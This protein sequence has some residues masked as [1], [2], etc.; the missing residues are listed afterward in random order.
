MQLSHVFNGH[1]FNA[2]AHNMFFV[3]WVTFFTAGIGVYVLNIFLR[4]RPAS[5]LALVNYCFPF[6]EWKT[7]SVRIDVFLY[8]L[9]IFTNGA[10]ALATDVARV[11]MAACVAFVLNAVVPIHTPWKADFPVVIML[12]VVL[13]VMTDFAGYVS[14]YLL[15]FVPCL[16][17]LHKVHHSATFLTPFT[18]RR[19]HPLENMF[20]GAFVAIFGAIPMGLAMHMYKLDLVSVAF[21]LATTN[22]FANIFILDTLKHSHFGASFGWLDRIFISP[23]VHQLHHSYKVEHWDKN[24]AGKLSIW[25]Q[26]FGTM[27]WPK[28]DEELPWGLGTAED[29]DF[30]TLWGVYI[31]PIIKIGRLWR[32]EP[33][34]HDPSMP[35][36]APMPFFDRFF[37][38]KAEHVIDA[39]HLTALPVAAE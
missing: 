38:R 31:G 30:D 6:K 9:S 18:V 2:L 21:L 36:P 13:F 25:D 34:W 5:L 19:T 4:K 16:W 24:F 22:T 11:A 27:V 3:A 23:H 35:K 29:R 28:R 20:S 37:W 14:H 8:I 12:V 26:L 1:L 10:V 33:S 7:K 17:E 15:H 39:E 32:G